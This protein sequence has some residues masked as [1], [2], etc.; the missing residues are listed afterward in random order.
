VPRIFPRTRYFLVSPEP[1]RA[2]LRRDSEIKRLILL[3]NRHQHGG[4]SLHM[5]ILDVCGTDWRYTNFAQRPIC[6]ILE[7]V[8]DYQVATTGVNF[9]QLKAQRKFR[10]GSI[11]LTNH[12]R[13]SV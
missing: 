11:D 4:R 5:A 8:L 1:S 10:Y 7:P 6:S 13:S 3:L 9:P 12:S 2:V